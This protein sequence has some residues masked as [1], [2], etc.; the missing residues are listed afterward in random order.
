MASNPDRQRGDDTFHPADAGVLPFGGDR[1]FLEGADRVFEQEGRRF[2][3][4]D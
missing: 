4:D 1:V 2:G 3:R